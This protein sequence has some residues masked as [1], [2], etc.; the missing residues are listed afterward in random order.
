[1]RHTAYAFMWLA[2]A[3]SVA[4]SV[5]K[6]VPSNAVH[7]KGRPLA[8]YFSAVKVVPVPGNTLLQT[9]LTGV[10]PTSSTVAVV[11]GIPRPAS[12]VAVNQMPLGVSNAQTATSSTQSHAVQSPALHINAQPV[13]VAQH[14]IATQPVQR[15]QPAAMIR[16]SN[17]PALVAL[18]SVQHMQPVSVAQPVIVTQPSHKSQQ[19]ILQLAVRP[20]AQPQTAYTAHAGQNARMLMGP[21]RVA[22]DPIS[23]VP[24]VNAFD[25]V[26]AISRSIDAICSMLKTISTRRPQLSTQ[27]QYLASIAPSTT[28]AQPAIITVTKTI[29]LV[30]AQPQTLV[31]AYTASVV[32][33]STVVRYVAQPASIEPK[34]LQGW[35]THKAVCN[36]AVARCILESGKHTDEQNGGQADDATQQYTAKPDAQ[37]GIS[38]DVANAE[39][40]VPKNTQ[41]NVSNPNEQNNEESSDSSSVSSSE[42]SDMCLD[43][44][45]QAKPKPPYVLKGSEDGQADDQ[46]Q[47]EQSPS[48]SSALSYNNMDTGEEQDQIVYLSDLI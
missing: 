24:V 40:S 9:A 7:L 31:P 11:S 15:I 43:D 10:Q 48:I 32:Q 44:C 1:M 47:Y 34:V 13:A 23:L 6:L 16:P 28:Y 2:L 21:I 4:C 17:A 26:K 33:P 12:P 25:M 5:I 37:K 45:T 36:I 30:P 19:P 20:H 39:T 35:I 41:D 29:S 27:P 3:A 46:G 22:V 8:T 18:P 42:S 14:V 38:Q